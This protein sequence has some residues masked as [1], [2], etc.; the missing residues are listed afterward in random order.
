MTLPS[1]KNRRDGRHA[2]PGSDAVR[3]LLHV[4]FDELL[5]GGVAKGVGDVFQE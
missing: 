4:E 2:P 3:R 1:R 5:A